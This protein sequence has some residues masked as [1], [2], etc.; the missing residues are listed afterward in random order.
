M[1]V[2]PAHA[3]VFLFTDRQPDRPGCLPRARGGVS[4]IILDKFSSL[5]S[6]PRTRGCFQ[7]RRSSDA[8]AAVFPAHAGVFLKPVSTY[9]NPVGLPRARGGVSASAGQ[10]LDGLRSSPRTR[11]CFWE[12]MIFQR[13]DV[14]FPAHAGVFPVHRHQ[15][16]KQQS[17]PRARGGVSKAAKSTSRHQV[18]SPR[19]RGWFSTSR[20]ERESSRVFPA[21]TGVFLV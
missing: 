15:R 10:D 5:M 6:S 16:P 1:K 18:S 3:G 4:L 20:P 7:W 13:H 14:V 21:H 12:Q 17:L 9:S 8:G 2:F 19:T 11:G